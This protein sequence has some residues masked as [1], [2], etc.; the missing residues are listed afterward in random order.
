MQHLS[1]NRRTIQRTETLRKKEKGKQNQ[2]TANKRDKIE[3]KNN[4]KKI[5]LLSQN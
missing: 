5:K 4:K 1:Q 2:Q 3:I